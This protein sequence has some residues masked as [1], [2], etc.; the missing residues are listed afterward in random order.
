MDV[1]KLISLIH[2]HPSLWDKGSSDYADNTA[3]ARS[4]V[5]VGNGMSVDFEKLT[6]REKTGKRESGDGASKKKKYM[7][8]DALEFLRN[9]VEKRSTSGNFE[10][11]GSQSPSLDDGVEED[12]VDSQ[13]TLPSASPWKKIGGKLSQR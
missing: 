10:R 6:E 1:D 3:R 2:G 7:Y 5:A 8:A 13:G 9:S 12:L 4:W 11:S